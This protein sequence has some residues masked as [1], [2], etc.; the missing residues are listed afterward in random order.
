[1][2]AP[3]VFGN[4]LLLGARAGDLLGS[5]R[6]FIVGLALFGVASLLMGTAQSEAC[7]IGARAF[8]GIGAAIVEPSSL[9]LI[10]ATFPAGRERTRAVAAYARPLGSAPVLARSLVVRWRRC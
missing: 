8:Q 3:L 7:I 9:S 5:R 6:V 4:L 1:M 2:P 10:T